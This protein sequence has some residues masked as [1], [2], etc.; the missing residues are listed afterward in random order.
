VLTAWGAPRLTE[1]P[2]PLAIGQVVVDTVA[3]LR[4]GSSE[5]LFRPLEQETE[6]E[7]A[8]AAR[9]GALIGHS[10]AMLELFARLPRVAQGEATVLLVGETGSGK[11]LVARELHRLSPRRAGPFVVVDCSALVE[12]LGEAELFGHV[13]GAFTGADAARVGLLE[14]ASGGTVFLDEIG[15]L[16]LPLQGQLLRVLDEHRI[17]RI[18]RSHD[19]PIDVRF[20]AATHRD[21]HQQVNQGAFRADLFFRLAVIVLGVAPLRRRPQDIAPLVEHF[22]TTLGAQLPHPPPDPPPELLQQLQ[23]Y[24]WPGNVREL[25]NFVERYLVTRGCD[26]LPGAVIPSVLAGR[27]IP[28]LDQLTT[29][30]FKEAKA[31]WAALFDAEYL[32]RLLL[33][34]Q[35]NLARAAEKSGLSRVHVFRLSKKYGID[36]PSDGEESG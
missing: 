7:L 4:L 32:R 20:I 15:E 18:G 6:V 11:G 23:E 25:R 34:S 16:P 28:E 22:F 10:P 19:Q 8:P 33:R 27:P 13:A 17:R 29:L 3:R 12:S 31:R 21:L 24:A 5:L 1:L 2:H 9:L 35:G 36:R 30:P 26:E 14:S